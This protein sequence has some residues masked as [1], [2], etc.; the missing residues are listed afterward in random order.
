L[1]NCSWN[2]DKKQ[3]KLS[4]DEEKQIQSSQPDYRFADKL[5]LDYRFVRENAARLPLVFRISLL[6]VIF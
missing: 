3:K 2:L 4:R 6:E 5:Q 1:K